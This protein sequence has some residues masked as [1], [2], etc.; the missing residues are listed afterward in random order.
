M[1]HSNPTKCT[2]HFHTLPFIAAIVLP[3]PYAAIL[4][5]LHDLHSF[6]IPASIWAA[7][8]CDAAFA[9]ALTVL[10]LWPAFCAAVLALWYALD[11][12]LC[13]NVLVFA[14]GDCF[15]FGECFG[16]ALVFGFFILFMGDG[17]ATASSCFG[18]SLSC[19]LVC[20]ANDKVDKSESCKEKFDFANCLLKAGLEVPCAI[21]LVLL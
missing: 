5:L 4:L 3:E 20:N 18:I 11:V 15:A 10:G 12:F 8:A 17:V 21:A 6:R 1:Q 14:F 2:I 7:T 9:L 13:L 19:V 16:F